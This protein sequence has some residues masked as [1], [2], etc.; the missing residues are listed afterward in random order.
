MEYY[1]LVA[2]VKLR[3]P[4]LGRPGPLDCFLQMRIA[5]EN[6]FVNSLGLLLFQF[7]QKDEP[8]RRTAA[9]V[10]RLS[11]WD[12]A[13]IPAALRSFWPL[14]RGARVRTPTKLTLEGYARIRPAFFGC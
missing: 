4:R 11:F 2:D 14:I 13:P 1:K 9:N 10:A 8:A 3:K 5:R 12:G 6:A 7:A